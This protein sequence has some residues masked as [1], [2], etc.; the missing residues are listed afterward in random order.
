MNHGEETELQYTTVIWYGGLCTNNMMNFQTGA[1]Y[2]A[3][4]IEIPQQACMVNH[5]TKI[6]MAKII[7][8]PYH[9]WYSQLCHDE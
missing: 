3:L 9:A 6:Q 2:S 1:K 5:A 4:C 8:T 7:V